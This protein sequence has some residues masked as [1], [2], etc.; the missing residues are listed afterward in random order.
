M[1]WYYTLAPWVAKPKGNDSNS[2][3]FVM[4]PFVRGYYNLAPCIAKPKGHEFNFLSTS[5]YSICT[6]FTDP[7]TLLDTICTLFTVPNLKRIK[8]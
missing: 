1:W 4:V 8:K 7:C 5:F 2:L 6:L 3:P